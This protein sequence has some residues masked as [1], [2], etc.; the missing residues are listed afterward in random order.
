[1]DKISC[2]DRKINY[3]LE[4]ID[5][6]RTFMGAIKARLWELVRHSLRHLKNLQNVIIEGI[7]DGMS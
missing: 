3:Y 4:I 6:N 5:E 7:I 2:I 1:M